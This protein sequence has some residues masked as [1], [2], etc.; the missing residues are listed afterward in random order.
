MY[1]TQYRG[2]LILSGSV[3]ASLYQASASTLRWH[4][5]FCSHWKQWSRFGM[6]L[7]PIF[8]RLYCFEWK[9]SHKRHRSIV[10]MLMLMLDVNR[11]IEVELL[12][13]VRNSSCVKVIFHRHLSFCS[14]GGVCIPA[15][16]G[17]NTP[18]GRQPPPPG[19]PLQRTV[20]ILLEC[21]LVIS[22]DLAVAVAILLI[23]NL[24]FQNWFVVTNSWQTPW[25]GDLGWL[26]SSS[27]AHS[28]IQ[29]RNGTVH[30]HLCDSVGF[31][32]TKA[33]LRLMNGPAFICRFLSD[34]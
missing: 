11:P 2:G 23:L 15:C 13:T 19:R 27:V 18:P 32:T 29:I 28:R 12:V 6:G 7:Q 1:W 14:H 20:R 16:T 24:E 8:K 3:R 5:R 33:L 22:C 9:Q 26:C 31:I 25:M 30:M 10:A 34:K 17:A 4:L 21:I